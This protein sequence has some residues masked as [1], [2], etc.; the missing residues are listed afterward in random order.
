MWVKI[1]LLIFVFSFLFKTDH[2]FDQDLGR[3]IK[4]GEIILKTKAIP[5]TN[6]FSY[7]NPDFPFINTHWLFEV[8][9]YVWST[10]LGFESLLILKIIIFLFSV[11]LIIKTISKQNQALLLPIGFIFLHVL[12]ERLELRPEIFSFLFTALTLYILEVSLRAK[13]GNLLFILPFIQLIWI[14]T[15]IY[16]FVG[17]ILQAIFLLKGYCTKILAF[18]FILSVI[19]SLINPNEL[20]GLLYPLNVNQNYGYTIVENQTMFFLENLKFSDPNFLFVKLSIA[21]TILSMLITSVKRLFNVKNI[22]ISLF[23]L[24]MALLNVRSFPY[25]IF[26]SLPA[27]L[28]NFGEIKKN[29][30]TRFLSF[31]TCILLLVESFFY[32]NGDY[33]KYKDMDNTVQLKLVESGKNSMD[34]VIKNDLPGPIF[35]NFDIGSYLAYRGYPKLKV[36]VDGRPEAYPKDFFTNIYI[37]SQYDYLKFKQLEKTLGFNTIIF[38]HTDQ[39][40]WG[41]NF[42]Q[43][44][45][46]D[47]DWRLVYT[48]DSII[49]LLKTEITNQKNLTAIDLNKLNPISYHYNNHLSY[50]RMGLFLINTQNMESGKQ[51]IDKTLEIFPQDPV[52]NSLY[53]NQTKNIFFW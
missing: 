26:L 6:L 15:H 25:L 2:S 22:L 27:V 31:I 40:P 44:V 20:K 29:S 41:K 18:V 5:N 33:Y 9:V 51:F 13:R 46:K 37:P 17:L 16:F 47:Q 52:A 1:L 45:V 14:N 42:L 50:L 23:G 10:S 11:W 43:N 32:L 3:H 36:F 28:S 53:N 38:S 21:I 30:F 49:V 48:D 12:R 19:L 24:T 4:L 8:F 34:F 7:T 35:N 39:T